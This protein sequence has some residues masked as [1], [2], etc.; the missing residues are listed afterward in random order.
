MKRRTKRGG[1]L[2]LTVN[3]N[4]SAREFYQRCGFSLEGEAETRFGPALRMSR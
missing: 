1:G 2:A 3:A 4:P